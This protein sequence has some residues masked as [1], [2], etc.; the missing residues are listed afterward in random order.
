[1][2]LVL[3]FL[4]SLCLL[5]PPRS[6]AQAPKREFRAAWIA[7]VSNIDWPSSRHLSPEAQRKEFLDRLDQLQNL[8]ANAVIVQVR[9]ACDAFYASEWEPWSRYL[10]GT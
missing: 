8:G 9:P 4:C 2:V 7:T 5:A 10:T 6:H 3:V 1:M